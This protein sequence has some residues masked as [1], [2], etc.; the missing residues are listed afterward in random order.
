MNFNVAIDGPSGAGKSSISKEVSKGVSNNLSDTSDSEN[1]SLSN[2]S[3]KE[4]KDKLCKR[5]SLVRY[6]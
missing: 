2:L 6:I 4:F 5:A 1:S 3:Y